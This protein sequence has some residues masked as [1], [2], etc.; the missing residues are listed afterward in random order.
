MSYESDKKYLKKYIAES[1]ENIT[2]LFEQYGWHK[3]SVIYALKRTIRIIKL[4]IIFRKKWGKR[5]RPFR[6][7][8]DFLQELL[9]VV[10]KT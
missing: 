6:G 8:A 3:K 5:T 7:I 9:G 10:K 2:I 1:I 4:I